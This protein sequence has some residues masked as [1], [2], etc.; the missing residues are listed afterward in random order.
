MNDI[1]D[2]IKLVHQTSDEEQRSAYEQSI[3]ILETLGEQ[4]N[5]EMVRFLLFR[6]CILDIKITHLLKLILEVKK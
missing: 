6:T 2:F 5:E 1:K 4:S 3:S